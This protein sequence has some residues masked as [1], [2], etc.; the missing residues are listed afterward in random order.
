ML[1]K[2]K[3]GGGPSDDVEAKEGDLSELKDAAAR[4]KQ[5]LKRAEEA[6]EEKVRAEQQAQKA[7]KAERRYCCGCCW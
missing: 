7:K 2:E 1:Q 5:L 4:A 3:I 6:K